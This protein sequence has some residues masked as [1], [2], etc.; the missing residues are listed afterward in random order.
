MKNNQIFGSQMKVLLA[1]SLIISLIMGILILL[2]FHFT[3]ISPGTIY[4]IIVN[5]PER[6][7]PP[8]QRKDFLRGVCRKKLK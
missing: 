4:S 2:R 5:I 8:G 7:C 6:T 1:I 3:T